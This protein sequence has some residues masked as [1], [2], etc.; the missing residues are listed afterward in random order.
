[1]VSFTFW[2]RYPW[3]KKTVG[4]KVRY[5]VPRTALEALGKRKIPVVSEIEP[6]PLALNTL[7]YIK[8]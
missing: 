6:G 2:H 7:K 5:F 3:E 4:W 8:Q 1:M